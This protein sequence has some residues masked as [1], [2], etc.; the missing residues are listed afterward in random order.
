[1]CESESDLLGV[2]ERERACIRRASTRGMDK[3]C[4]RGKCMLRLLLPCIAGVH[5]SRTESVEIA[6]EY[7]DG[8]EESESPSEEESDG[9]EFADESELHAEYAGESATAE[10]GEMGEE[11]VAR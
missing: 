3:G 6:S 9:L 11:A 2:A 5:G 7:A 10:R 1:M 4:G 8:L